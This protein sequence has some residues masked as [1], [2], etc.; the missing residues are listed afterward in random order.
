MVNDEIHPFHRS[1]CVVNNCKLT[2]ANRNSM[3]RKKR[4]IFLSFAA[5]ICWLHPPILNNSHTDFICE[6]KIIG[7]YFIKKHQLDFYKKKNTFEYFTHCVFLIFSSIKRI[8]YLGYKRTVV[9]SVIAKENVR[10]VISCKT[11]V[12][13]R[14][15]GRT[16]SR[17]DPDIFSVIYT[18]FLASRIDLE[19][20]WT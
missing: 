8:W 2:F 18:K 6:R 17:K 14:Y 4:Y 13:F 12:F 1:W 7:L 11:S 5:V 9:I 3:L 10:E 16:L 15:L 20:S 19:K